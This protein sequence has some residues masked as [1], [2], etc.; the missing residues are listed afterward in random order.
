MAD[1][2]LMW[3]DVDQRVKGKRMS[4][5]QETEERDSSLDVTEKNEIISIFLGG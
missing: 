1:G 2:K 5:M 3:N 4:W